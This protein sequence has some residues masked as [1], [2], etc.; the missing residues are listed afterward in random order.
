MAMAAGSPPASPRL[1]SV[2]SEHFSLA[3]RGAPDAP[4][5]LD[6][7]ATAM[8]VGAF[9]VNTQAVQRSC[10]A[11]WHVW[12]KGLALLKGHAPSAAQPVPL[13]PSEAMVVDVPPPFSGWRRSSSQRGW[14]SWLWRLACL[15]PRLASGRCSR[16]TSRWPSAVRL[17][18][19]HAQSSLRLHS[20]LAEHLV[21]ADRFGLRSR[22]HSGQMA[23]PG[24]W[25]MA[26][27]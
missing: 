13:P 16:S 23:R 11:A 17:L 14:P 7:A 24:A 21:L 26:R 19:G 1:R 6:A 8:P 2:L 4:V 20:K 3:I 15:R 12:A 10:Q 9:G 5:T 25:F 22:R 27:L 18:K